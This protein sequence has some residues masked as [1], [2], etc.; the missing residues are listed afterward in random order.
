MLTR[1]AQIGVLAVL[2]LC[3]VAGPAE[4]FGRRSHCAQVACSPSWCPSC[5]CY[6]YSLP[7]EP[8][9]G[10]YHKT[11]RPARVGHGV[12]VMVDA[13]TGTATHP[14]GLIQVIKTGGHGE[15]R[16]EGY[17]A[18]RVQPPHPGSPVRWSIFLCPTHA[19]QVSIEVGFVMSNNQI[20]NVPFAFDIAPCP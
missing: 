14:T 12:I 15:L 20:V 13:P 11:I 9:Y 3:V 1:V 6:H 2:G 17:S 7:V 19:G 4:A 16:Y 18:C 5:H 10:P 8:L